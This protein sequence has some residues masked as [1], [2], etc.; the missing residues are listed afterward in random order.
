MQ[1]S[2]KESMLMHQPPAQVGKYDSSIAFDMYAGRESFFPIVWISERPRFFRYGMLQ[3]KTPR[4]PIR[5]IEC[6]L[7]KTCLNFQLLPLDMW[8]QFIE[9]ETFSS[10]RD[11]IS[12]V[13]WFLD[14]NW[15]FRFQWTGRWSTRNLLNFGAW[16]WTCLWSPNR[17]RNLLRWTLASWWNG[18]VLSWRQ[19]LLTRVSTQFSNRSNVLYFD[20]IRA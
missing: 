19:K 5:I 3:A 7:C 1:N 2:L 6:A 8:E 10:N 9:S 12:K 17:T 20:L 11:N 4:T 13:R 15:T 18:V 16:W 14:W